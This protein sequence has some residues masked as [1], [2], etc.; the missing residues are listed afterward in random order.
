MT[1]VSV[2]FWISEGTTNPCILTED[3]PETNK[4]KSVGPFLRIFLQQNLIII[5]I[6]RIRIRNK[7]NTPYCYLPQDFLPQLN[8]QLH[9]LG[10]YPRP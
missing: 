1:N 8:K 10:F 2:S 6:L 5:R 9:F 3:V 4:C 7:N